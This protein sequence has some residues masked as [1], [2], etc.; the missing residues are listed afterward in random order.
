MAD[1]ESGASGSRGQGRNGRWAR[2][3]TP[4]EGGDAAAQADIDA[5]E[6]AMLEAA[7]G[8]QTLS[9]GRGRG[10]GRRGSPGPAGATANAAAK[11]SDVPTVA[12]KAPALSGQ[13]QAF[14]FMQTA[15]QEEAQKKANKDA[16]AHRE[17][18]QWVVP[19]FESEC[20]VADT[21][22]EKRSAESTAAPA[23]RLHRRSYKGFNNVVELW[24]KDQLKKNAETV[25]QAEEYDQAATL[26][27]MK[28]RRVGK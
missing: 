11:P 2:G 18:M 24:M 9:T 4:G 3:A 27:G 8:M 13:I 7:S 21:A 12:E 19:G 23:L 6:E 17:E 25:A 14:K 22:Q 1:A 10:R 15:I 5:S 26:R 20:Q 16:L 28:Q